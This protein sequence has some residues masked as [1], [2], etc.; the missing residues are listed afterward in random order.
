MS[1]EGIDEVKGESLK[2]VCIKLLEE[3]KKR[4]WR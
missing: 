1:I 3:K 2:D 4:G